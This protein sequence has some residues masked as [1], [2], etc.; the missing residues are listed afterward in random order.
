[1]RVHPSC[2]SLTGAPPSLGLTPGS[3]PDL[4]TQRRTRMYALL[5]LF[6]YTDERNSGGGFLCFL[7][8]FR[9][10]GAYIHNEA[11]FENW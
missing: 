10:Q 11:R 6:G 2:L 4:H 3:E 1:M 9:K 7:T 8:S 5:L